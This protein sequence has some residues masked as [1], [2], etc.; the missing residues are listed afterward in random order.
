MH[1]SLDSS[2]LSYV[3]F[4]LTQ[5]QSPTRKDLAEQFCQ[6]NHRLAEALHQHVALFEGQCRAGC[7]WAIGL[8]QPEPMRLEIM[9][10]AAVI[11]ISRFAFSTAQ[12]CIL[13]NTFHNL[14]IGWNRTMSSCC[15]QHSDGSSEAA[16]SLQ[17]SQAIDQA[18]QCTYKSEAASRVVEERSTT[19]MPSTTLFSHFNTCVISF[20]LPDPVKPAK[21]DCVCMYNSR[22]ESSKVASYANTNCRNQELLESVGSRLA[23]HDRLHQNGSPALPHFQRKLPKG[24][25]S[26]GLQITSRTWTCQ[27]ISQWPSIIHDFHDQPIKRKSWVPLGEYPRYI[28]TYTTYI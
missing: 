25:H 9:S 28:P 6:A 2:S 20:N 22:L 19:P 10:I 18:H 24:P 12:F 8:N 16:Q 23:C 1:K 11:F 7:S 5:P 27:R 13:T 17:R 21:G 4:P 15:T 14:E 26:S 3:A